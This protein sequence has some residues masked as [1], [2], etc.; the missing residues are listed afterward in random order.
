M[1][2]TALFLVN[3]STC[4]DKVCCYFAVLWPRLFGSQW[5]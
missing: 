5:R 4:F 3:E 2:D 1:T